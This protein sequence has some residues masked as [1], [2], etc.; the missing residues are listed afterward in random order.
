MTIA[1]NRHHRAQNFLRRL[2][3]IASDRGVATGNQSGSAGV[4][5]PANQSMRAKPPIPNE[6]QQIPSRGL[7]RPKRAYQ[8]FVA[9]PQR[10]NHAAPSHPDAHFMT[11][12]HGLG[13]EF[14]S[15]AVERIAHCFQSAPPIYSSP[16]C[17]A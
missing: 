16:A 13:D 5:H 6:E 7:C 2:R 3:G 12:P 1:K 11:R 8:Q 14:A 4:I 17:D 15:Y 10:R 9:R